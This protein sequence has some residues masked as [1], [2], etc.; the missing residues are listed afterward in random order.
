MA[1]FQL[2]E[3]QKA[4][5]DFG[6]DGWLLYDF[7]GNNPLAGRVLNFPEGRKTSRRWCYCIPATGTPSKLVHRIEES[8]LDELPGEKTVYLPWQ[9]FEAGLQAFCQGK[10]KIAMEYSPMGGNPYVSRVDAGT[11]ELVRS[12]GVDVVSSGDLIQLFESTWTEEQWQQHLKAAEVTN[13]AYDVAWK[14][15]ADRV[16]TGAGVSE[17]EVEEAIM[18]FFDAS[19]MTTYHPPIVARNEH[20]GSPHYETATGADTQIRE[21]DFVLIDLWAKLDEPNSVYSDLTRV[22]YVGNEVPPKYAE[23][24]SIV[25]AARDTGIAMVR[26]AMASGDSLKGADVDQAVRD[27]I[28]KHGYGEYFTHR[29]GHNI[30]QEVHGNGAHLDNLETREDRQLLPGTCFSIEPGIYLKEFGV[31]L[32]VDVYIDK[33]KQVHVTGGALQQE[34]IPILR[35]F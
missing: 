23:I 31:R 7:R 4:L 16:R 27:V 5:T 14:L 26:S 20:S 24:F 11:V 22:G 30:G 18:S 25:A 13:K 15:I 28:I 35:D 12:F 19:G 34:V 9:Q 29:T 1:S 21:N 3:I 6:I 8:V 2:S 33:A 32:E 17:K 10:Q